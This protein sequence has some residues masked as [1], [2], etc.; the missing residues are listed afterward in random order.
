LPVSDG[1]AGAIA[2]S[3]N[4]NS[5]IDYQVPL[6]TDSRSSP[7]GND[8]NNGQRT[9]DAHLSVKGET[10][11]ATR[12]PA[13]AVETINNKLASVDQNVAD[14]LANIQTAVNIGGGTSTSILAA[15]DVSIIAAHVM[16][17]S[18][19]MVCGVKSESLLDSESNSHV[20]QRNHE[21]NV[22]L[23]GSQ[24]AILQGPKS[25][26]FIDMRS[27]EI[28]PLLLTGSETNGR[29]LNESATASLADSN[30][31][32]ETASHVS[33]SFGT[34]QTERDGDSCKW[35]SKLDTESSNQIQNICPG[36]IN[37]RDVENEVNVGAIESTLA[38]KR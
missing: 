6:K 16:V 22:I 38:K 3:D 9:M 29:S 32:G 21:S 11:E 19:T 30:D 25:E 20:D 1:N 23:H 7:L 2:R 12:G 34:F 4:P 24:L 27:N 31:N 33:V 13:I 28:N 35:I 10:L 5:G 17:M 26:V 18:D 37:L 14:A 36:K 15:N 8:E